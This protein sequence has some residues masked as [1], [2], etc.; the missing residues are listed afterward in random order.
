MLFLPGD[1]L[2]G[3]GEGRAAPGAALF[4]AAFL[5]GDVAR[6]DAPLPFNPRFESCP[7]VVPVV[8]LA[9][10]AGF[11]LAVPGATLWRPLTEVCLLLLITIKLLLNEP[12]Y[13]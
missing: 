9:L 6:A 5:A 2:L 7:P 13:S 10:V 11:L 4:G 12:I 3:L 1:G 8:T